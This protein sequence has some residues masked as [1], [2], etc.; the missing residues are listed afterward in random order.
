MLGEAYTPDDE[1]DSAVATISAVMV[2]QA[3]YRVGLTKAQAG[4]L[5]LIEV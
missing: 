2:Y 1:E 3:R 5:V 4:S